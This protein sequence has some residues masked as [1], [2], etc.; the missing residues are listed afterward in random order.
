MYL[1]LSDVD[2]NVTLSRAFEV[3]HDGVDVIGLRAVEEVSQRRSI[4]EEKAHWRRS[5]GEEKVC[6]R[7]SDG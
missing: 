5:D 3:F 1:I 7:R 2:D 4:E 6:R